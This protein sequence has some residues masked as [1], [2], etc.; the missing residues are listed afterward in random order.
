MGAPALRPGMA[1]IMH[2]T[3]HAAGC[4]APP[5]ECTSALSLQRRCFSGGAPPSPAGASSRLASA[6]SAAC[7]RAPGCP[8]VGSAPLSPAAAGADVAVAC[9]ALRR[10]GTR[11]RERLSVGPEGLL[12]G[13]FAGGVRRNWSGG[14]W[15]LGLGWS[16]QGARKGEVVVGASVQWGARAR[17]CQASAHRTRRSIHRTAQK[18]GSERAPLAARRCTRGIGTGRT[19]AR[20]SSGFETRQAAQPSFCPMFDRV[21]GGGETAWEV[22]IKLEAVF[23]D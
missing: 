6:P 16:W 11:E 4:R 13:R 20:S 12:A 17:A 2:G 9:G 18:S 10:A 23:F 1:G 15:D 3:P 8:R 22:E 21:K 5:A 19:S 14:A 7:A